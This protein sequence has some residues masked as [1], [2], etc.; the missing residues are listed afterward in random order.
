MKKLLIPIFLLFHSVVFSQINT[1]SLMNVLLHSKKFKHVG[2]VGYLMKHFQKFKTTD[3]LENYDVYMDSRKKLKEYMGLSIVYKQYD[4]QGRIAKRIGY[5]LKGKYSLWDYSP[6]EIMSYSKDTATTEYYNSAYILTDK[7]TEIKDTLGRLIETLEYDKHLNPMSR[8]VSGYTDSLNEVLIK[9]YDG[10]GKFRINSQGVA[11][12]RQKFDTIN[13]KFIIEEYFY[14]STM[15]L[16]DADHENLGGNNGTS[17]NYSEIKNHIESGETIS[18][19]YNSKGVLICKKSGV[20]VI[21]E[22]IEK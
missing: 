2:S 21:I 13:K 12:R 18:S 5:S 4:K 14:D 20:E 3:G 6:I 19:Y 17:L 8:T 15:K 22:S 7:I 16:V 1:D 9:Y 10:Q 11:I